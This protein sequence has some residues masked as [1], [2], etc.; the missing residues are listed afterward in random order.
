MEAAKTY[1]KL[2]KAPKYRFVAFILMTLV[3]ILT[4]AGLQ[5]FN[6]AGTQIMNDFGIRESFLSV[7]SSCGLATMA[8][9][10]LIVFP[11]LSKKIGDKPALPGRI[12]PIV[13]SGL[14][15]W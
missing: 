5:V 3:Y 12:G 14:C 10:S 2:K 7:L 9:C 1:P 8:V 15:I 4:Y 13:A 6:S 11:A